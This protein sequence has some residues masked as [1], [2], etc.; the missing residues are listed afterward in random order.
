MNCSSC[1]KAIPDGFT[2]C[3]WC[4]EPFAASPSPAV[5]PSAVSLKPVINP[6]A[7]ALVFTM[8]L[9]VVAFAAY[10]ST[11]RRYGSV[12]LENSAYFLGAC[13]G[14]YAVSAIIILVFYLITRRKAHNSTKLIAAFFAASFFAF[15]SLIAPTPAA[16]P[17]AHN[18]AAP[19]L[20]PLAAILK[21]QIQTPPHTPTIW[22]PAI[23]S[24]YSDLKANNEAY[25]A[26]VSHLDVTAEPLYLPESF[27][28]APTIQKILAQL[29][30]RLAVADQFSSLD[31]ILAKMPQ[32]VA[33]INASDSD[34][35]QFLATFMPSVQQSVADRKT[36]SAYEHNW[37]LATTALYQFMLA[38]QSAYAISADGKKGA[39]L[40]QDASSQFTA[41]MATAQRLKQQF[42]QAQRAYLA[43]QSAAR[44]QM[45]MSD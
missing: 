7:T 24:L 23:I 3:P 40:R 11:A 25:V 10:L 28:G 34:K 41:R 20:A 42:L 35:Q 36:A 6:T 33:A 17:A 37:L 38:N 2:E 43:T 29:Q 4:G 18:V 8:S 44:T 45:G 32:Y 12:S 39:F 1:S 15:V 26:A 9:V 19:Q 16:K 14:P 31:P 22:D 21:P 27:R 5:S 30:D 13:A